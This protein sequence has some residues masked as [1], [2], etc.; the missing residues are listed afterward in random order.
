[1]MKT[2]LH[3]GIET[4]AGQLWCFV[5]MTLQDDDHLAAVE[6]AA[7]AAAANLSQ[8]TLHPSYYEP[9]HV[10][11]ALALAVANDSADRLTQVAGF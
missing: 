5:T 6:I 9:V 2:C 11:M 3:C 10:L 7:T 1:M 8:N 4:T